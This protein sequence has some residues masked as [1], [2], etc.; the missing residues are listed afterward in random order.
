MSRRIFVTVSR[1][2]TDKTAVCVFPWEVP[3]LQLVHQQE[4][5]AV[6]IDELCKM[7]EGVVKV[8]K[9]KQKHSDVMPPDLRQQYEIMAYVEPDEDP[10]R[11]PAGEYERMANK[12][13]MDKELPMTCVARIY[14]EFS[15][16]NFERALKEHAEDC[17]PRPTYLK[18]M[19]EG[20]GKA[21]AD[22][23]VGELRKE[24]TARGLKWAV[25]EGHTELVAKLEAALAPA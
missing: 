6:S 12:Y 15:T 2:M 8:E 25:R 13:G 17:A 22:M 21:P 18:S 14:G 9:Q 3:I 24:L 20:M 16:G 23:T 11:D 4:V 19:D 10:A 7:R 5:E 1:G